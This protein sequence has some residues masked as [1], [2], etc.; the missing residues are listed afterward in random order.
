MILTFLEKVEKLDKAEE[1]AN[2][3]IVFEEKGLPYIIR[4][5]VYKDTFTGKPDYCYRVEFETSTLYNSYLIDIA[6]CIACYYYHYIQALQL[7]QGII[8]DNEVESEQGLT[9]YIYREL[10]DEYISILNNYV[11]DQ[12]W[13]T[14]K[15]GN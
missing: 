5:K 12:E 14:N 13:R 15:N 10:V 2:G 11:W 9:R 7:K 4:E 1:T 3:K 6:S 8:K